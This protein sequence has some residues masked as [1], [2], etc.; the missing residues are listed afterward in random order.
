MRYGYILFLLLIIGCGTTSLKRENVLI[1]AMLPTQL[2][3]KGNPLTTYCK[4]N[5]HVKKLSL[6]VN[7]HIPK[8]AKGIVLDQAA[9][10]KNGF[11]KKAELRLQSLF[12][13]LSKE[14]K[15][16][17]KER[18]FVVIDSSFLEAPF[19]NSKIF[20]L[21]ETDGRESI[22]IVIVNPE[23][24]SLHIG[25]SFP[26]VFKVDYSNLNHKSEKSDLQDFVYVIDKNHK[27]LKTVFSFY[28]TVPNHD[29]GVVWVRRKREVE[30]LPMYPAHQDLLRDMR[31]RYILN[32]PTKLRNKLGM[33]V[34]YNLA[35]KLHNS[36]YDWEIYLNSVTSVKKSISEDA[37]KLK[38]MI[39]ADLNPF[40]TY[41]VEKEGFLTK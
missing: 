3:K 15:Y 31:E 35:D 37:S 14:K 32:F 5:K 20:S 11:I 28:E 36:D 13:Q 21:S 8:P 27:P 26:V 22:P 24:E 23:D 2:N 38:Y 16:F 6:I 34:R 29:Y 25:A 30:V 18:N 10:L 9:R 4:K 33:P 12:Y 1:N 39:K 17:S 7:I 19:S 40:C 41:A